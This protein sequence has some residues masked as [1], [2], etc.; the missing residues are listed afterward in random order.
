MF[1]D[2]YVRNTMLLSS[3]VVCYGLVLVLAKNN[4]LKVERRLRNMLGASD[5]RTIAERLTKTPLDDSQLAA[6]R[7]GLVPPIVTSA[8]H[9]F[10][11]LVSNK[12]LLKIFTA[13]SR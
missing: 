1:I 11:R 2:W 10:F 5:A 8:N 13:R 3:I 12:S 6:L 9:V 4:L 7:S